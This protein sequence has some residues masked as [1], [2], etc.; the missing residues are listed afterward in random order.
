MQFVGPRGDR[1]VAVDVEADRAR[2]VVQY[3]LQPPGEAS[4]RQRPA[5]EG[6]DVLLRDLDDDDAALLLDLCR[7]QPGADV[8]GGKLQ[9]LQH[10]AIPQ[11]EHQGGG[12]ERPDEDDGI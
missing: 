4:V 7:C 2:V 10:P 5:A 12:K 9:E 3:P 6:L 8:V 11:G 1:D